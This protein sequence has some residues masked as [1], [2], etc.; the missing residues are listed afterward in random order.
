[1]VRCITCNVFHMRQFC[2]FFYCLAWFYTVEFNC[3][4]SPNNEMYDDAVFTDR[5]HCQLTMFGV[6]LL[7]GYLDSF[8]IMLHMKR[9]M[10]KSSLHFNEFSIVSMIW[11]DWIQSTAMHKQQDV[12]WCGFR[13]SIPI[14]IEYVWSVHID[15]AI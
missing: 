10:P 6:R 14:S 12:R 4:P 15:R 9:I 8:M 7:I 3:L 1:M 13:F 2:R 5:F 11:Y